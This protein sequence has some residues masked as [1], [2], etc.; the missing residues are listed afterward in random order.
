MFFEEL[1][2]L[3]PFLFVEG[4]VSC[5]AKKVYHFSEEHADAVQYSPTTVFNIHG[6]IVKLVEINLQRD[7]IKLLPFLDHRND[8]F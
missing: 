8:Y 5:L 6:G 7:F 3:K 1:V 2:K 4:V